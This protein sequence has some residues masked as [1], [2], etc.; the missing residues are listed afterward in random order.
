MFVLIYMHITYLE[1]KKIYIRGELNIPFARLRKEGAR[2][3]R[4][5]RRY[6]MENKNKN[7]NKN[8]I[9]QIEHFWSSLR[10][11]YKYKAVI[12]FY[13]NTVRLSA[14]SSAL[15]DD[16]LQERGPD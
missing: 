11:V 5:D 16:Y 2:R 13:M 4:A 7:K 14:A 15:S 6:Q 3:S 12:S 10:A 8:R 9:F 1:R